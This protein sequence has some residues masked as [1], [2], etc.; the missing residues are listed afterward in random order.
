M[1]ITN[2]FDMYE[3]EDYLIK[4]HQPKFA[5][6]D[7]I[8]KL[9]NTVT[10]REHDHFDIGHYV[11]RNSSGLTILANLFMKQWG[12][13]VKN[14][15]DLCETS[16]EIYIDEDGM[17]AYNIDFLRVDVIHEGSEDF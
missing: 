12:V 9:I 10:W 6:W 2:K 14:K 7:G 1:N 11:F 8:Y 16:D 17:Y 3:D 13:L 15:E 5:K 4:F